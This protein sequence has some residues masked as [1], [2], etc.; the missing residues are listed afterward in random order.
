MAYWLIPVQEDMWLTIQQVKIYGYNREEITELVKPGDYM[1]FYVS[2]YYAKRYGGK[3]VGIMKVVSDWYEDETPIFP[4]EQV[5]NK[6]IYNYRVKL[7]PVKI[8]VCDL[9]N[10]LY[11]VSFIED[12]YQFAKY[13]RN[14][15]ANLRRPVPEPDIK[16][17]EE[18]MEETAKKSEE[19]II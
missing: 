11:K 9:K 5:R 2:K 8:G 15:P 12:K 7:E 18:C 4:E 6:G 17:I 1:V 16:L 14:A 3:F 19:E 13:L 10:I